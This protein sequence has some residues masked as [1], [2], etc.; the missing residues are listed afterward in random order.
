MNTNILKEFKLILFY[1]NLINIIFN[2][3]YVNYTYKITLICILFLILSFFESFLNIFIN[4]ESFMFN[5]YLCKNIHRYFYDI[6][7]ISVKSKYRYIRIYQYL[8]PYL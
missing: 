4:F 8:K 3:T 1:K 2:D 5:Q 7:D 6:Y